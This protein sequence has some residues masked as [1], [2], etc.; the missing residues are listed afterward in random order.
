MYDQGRFVRIGMATSLL[1][2]GAILGSGS[3]GCEATKQSNEIRDGRANPTLT[4]G[5]VQ[6]EIREGMS[7]AE[8]LEKLGSPNIVSTDELGR[9]VWVYERFA[10]DVTSSDAGFFIVLFGTGNKSSSV[11]Q[12]SLTVIIKFDEADKVRDFAYH[13]SSF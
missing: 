8:V 3:L 7:G 9:E 4:T 12:R 5:T 2:V 13:S 11:S 10:R 1:V 6:R